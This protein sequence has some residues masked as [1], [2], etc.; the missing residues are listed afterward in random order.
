MFDKCIKCNRLGDSCVPNLMLLSLADLM[1]WCNK[2]Q[3]YLEWTNQDLAEKSGVPIGTI[4]RIKAGEYMDCRYSTIKHIIIALVGG[5]SDEFSC[6]ELVEKELK[7]KEELEQQAAKLSSVECENAELKLKLAGIDEQ[8]RK[9]I[10]AVKEEYQ[11]QICFLKDELKAWRA[12]HQ[13]QE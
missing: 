12:W 10:R 2:R 3:K 5:T 8:H 4:S 13:K 11:E 9:D 1:Q 7:H 6:T